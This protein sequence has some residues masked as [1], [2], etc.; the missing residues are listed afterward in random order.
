MRGQLMLKKI[1]FVLKLSLFPV[2]CWPLPKDATRFKITCVQLYH[3][4]LIISA[5]IAEIS[6]IYTI[7]NNY[8][9]IVLLV[10]IILYLSCTVHSTENYI[11]HTIFRKRIQF[12]TFEMIEFSESIQP[13]EDVIIERYIDKCVMLYG[14]SLFLL[15]VSGFWPSLVPFL[16]DQPFPTPIQYPESLNVYDQPLRVIIYIHQTAIAIQIAAQI[17]T[18]S[19]MGLLL[20]ITSAR[21]EMLENELQKTTD[22]YDLAKC[23]RK[24]QYLLKCATEVTFAARPFVF[25]SICCSTICTIIILLLFL[26]SQSMTLIYQYTGFVGYCL[27][28]IFMY[29]WPA[30]NLIHRSEVFAQTAYDIPW[31]DQ[32]TKIRKCLEIIILRSQKPITV[33]IPCVMASLSLSYFTSYFSTIVSYF[34]TL[35]IFLNN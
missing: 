20:W 15:Y 14:V 9:D 18:N 24:H 6:M 11:F 3:L 13:H 10:E 16:T 32:S 33:S 31:Y 12:V 21:L 5:I 17:S 29:A 19:L 30:E 28:E 25:S 34:T 1:I 7:Y 23:I 35:R 26:T 2:L 27:A 4:L 8:N 22:I